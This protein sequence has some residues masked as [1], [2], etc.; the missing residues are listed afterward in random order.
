MI[1]REL[2]M[3]YRG[4]NSDYLVTFYG[5]YSAWLCIRL[6]QEYMDLG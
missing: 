2:E 6:Y 5:C 4:I 1:V 3:M